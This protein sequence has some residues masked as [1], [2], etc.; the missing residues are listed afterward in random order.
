VVGSWL[1]ITYKRNEVCY[2]KK[3]PVKNIKIYIN[4]ENKNNNNNKNMQ[5]YEQ[6]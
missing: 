1:V 5:K 6:I 2:K 3:Y 4:F